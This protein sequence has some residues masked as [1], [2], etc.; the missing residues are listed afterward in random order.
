MNKTS[1]NGFRFNANSL[2]AVIRLQLENGVQARIV[3]DV[4]DYMS[5][6]SIKAILEMALALSSSDR[7]LAG[8]I[9]AAVD[10]TAKTE[11]LAQKH[12]KSSSSKMDDFDNKSLMVTSITAKAEKK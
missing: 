5:V 8:L 7:A 4:L 2:E 12:Q 3:T 10:H 9:K 6:F 11:A 1:L